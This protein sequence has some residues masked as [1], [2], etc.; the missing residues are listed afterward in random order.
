ML[1]SDDGE[2]GAFLPI[3][4]FTLVLNGEPFIRHHIDVFRELPFPWH[5]HVVEGAASL[6]HDTGWSRSQGGVLSSQ[7]HD[8]GRSVD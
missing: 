7:F 4:F 1:R 3:H 8:Q 6:N 2:P 5:W